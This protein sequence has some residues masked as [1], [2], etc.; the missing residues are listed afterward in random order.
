MRLSIPTI[1]GL[2]LDNINPEAITP[3]ADG[4][5]TLRLVDGKPVYPLRNTVIRDSDGNTVR[6]S[7]VKVHTLPTATID[8]LTPLRCINCRITP[9]LDGRQIALSVVADHVEP[10]IVAGTEVDDE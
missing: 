4:D 3:Q 6:A 9:W 8:A 7:S 1:S 10:L 2:A 5:G